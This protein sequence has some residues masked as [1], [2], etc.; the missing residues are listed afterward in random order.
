VRQSLR[1][2]GGPAIGH[3]PS[4]ATE[5][6]YSTVQLGNGVESTAVEIGSRSSPPV[7]ALRA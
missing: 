1:L 7:A 3:E 4:G 2:R 6:Q 5:S